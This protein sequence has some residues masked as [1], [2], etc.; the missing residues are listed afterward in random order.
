MKRFLTEEVGAIAGRVRVKPE[1]FIVEE[2]LLYE[3]CGEGTHLW[4][5]IEKTGRTTFDAVRLVAKALGRRENEI[6]HAGLK[7][8]HAITRQTLTIE[9]ATEDDVRRLDIPGLRVLNVT[10]HKNKLKVGHLA[11]N[12]FRLRI[13]GTR[14]GDEETARRA[15]A[16]LERRGVPNLFGPQRF[17][18]SGVTPRLGRALLAEDYEAFLAALGDGDVLAARARRVWQRRRN[19]AAAVRALPRRFLALCTSAVQS[20][21][22][23]RVLAQ[24]LGTLDSLVP[25]DVAYLHRNGACFL[26]DDA[27]VEAPR[28][29]RFE[30]SPSGPLPGP[31]CLRPTGP[32]ADL[33]AEVLADLGLAHEVFGVRRPWAQQ[34]GRRPLRVPLSAV[35]LTPESTDGAVDLRLA[36][37]LPRGSFATAVLAELLKRHHNLS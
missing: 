28:V 34:G 18:S 7:D 35:E 17:G 26:V 27:V 9:F 23:N 24:R 21:V 14:P 25:G 8:K 19:P 29:R 36:F 30:L 20:E 13:R 4:L 1:D 15:L 3:P 32:Q 6:G 33:E 22:F 11:G 16:I 31:S 10:R 12:R 5:T 37:E 2:V